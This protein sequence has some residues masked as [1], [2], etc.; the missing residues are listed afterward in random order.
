[1]ASKA[2][3]RRRKKTGRTVTQAAP[4]VSGAPKSANTAP[5]GRTVR[6]TAERMAHGHWAMP[7]GQGKEFQPAVDLAADMVG[8]LHVTRQITSSHEQSAR[9]WQ[10]LR[11]R[12]LAELPEVQSY[13]SCLAGS[14]PGYDD[15]DGNPEVI[16]A[17]RA[18]ERS[19]T[20]DQRR[21]MIWT[22]DMDHKPYNLKLLKSALDV[23]AGA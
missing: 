10:E 8:W 3:L 2:E 15:G 14:V 13:K 9:A 12:Y 6:P 1:M 23:I 11:A 21:A 19:M 5:Q 18:M 16:R 4:E 7:A 20:Q 22:C 17:Y